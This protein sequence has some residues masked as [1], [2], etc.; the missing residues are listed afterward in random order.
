MEILDK[1]NPEFIYICTCCKIPKPNKEFYKRKNTTRSRIYLTQCAKCTVI[2][3]SEYNKKHKDEVKLKNSKYYKEKKDTILRD[4]R[5]LK[6]YGINLEEYNIMFE[7]QNGVCKICNNS[8]MFHKNKMLCVDHDHV[9]G[10]VRGLLCQ[11]CNTGLGNLRDSI[12]NLENAIKYLK[13]NN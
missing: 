12:E 8:E 10:K 13:E 11:G 3:T 1:N 4:R 6:V 2:K 7:K 5:Y 9:T